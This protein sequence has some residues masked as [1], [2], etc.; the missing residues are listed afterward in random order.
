MICFLRRLRIMKKINSLID[1]LKFTTRE[2]YLFSIRH[3]IQL[4]NK[5]L[6]AH[7]N[8]VT[9]NYFYEDTPN[10]GDCLS[11]IVVEYMLQK[12]GLSLDTPTKKTKHLY[13]IGSILFFGHQ[14]A[15]VW[16]SGSLTKL[17]SPYRSLLH[18]RL[19]RKL[20]IRCVRGPLSATILR[21]RGFKC[22]DIY[23]D[24]G[25]LMPLI[26]SPKIEKQIDYLVIPHISNE[27]D[28]FENVPAKNIISMN[29]EDYKQVIDKICSA[30]RVIS[31]SLHGI[32]LAE[33][34]G[35]PAVFYNDRN[36]YFDFK[37]VDWYQ[38]TGR[39]NWPVTTN[40]EEAIN[41]PLNNSPLDLSSMQ[42]QL[43]DSFP[44][45]LWES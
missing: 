6:K 36:S 35:V 31:S 19:F 33:A 45:D 2:L 30:K 21:E 3:S 42:K 43:I 40:L 26:Y 27:T 7:K 20:D 22:P 24:P 39:T 38:S 37:Y 4:G 25:C 17:G 41:M 13:A 11:P 9:L 32:I 28:L 8:K 18:T 34:Y 14:N 5:N 29:T 12:R 15:T 1:K 16:G 44:Y 23:G 10:L